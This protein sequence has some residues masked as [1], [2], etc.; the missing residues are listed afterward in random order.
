M[1][2]SVT[3]VGLVFYF[4]YQPCNFLPV[5]IGLVISPFCIYIYELYYIITLGSRFF[6]FLLTLIAVFYYTIP[7][8][9]IFFIVFMVSKI[10]SKNKK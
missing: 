3:A 1:A 7:V 6:P 8:S 9:F 10:I 5:L 2:Y 4:K